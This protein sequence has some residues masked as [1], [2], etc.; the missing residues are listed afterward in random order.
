MS[1]P[2]LSRQRPSTRQPRSAAPP[3]PPHRLGDPPGTSGRLAGRYRY[4]RRTI[5]W[6]SQAAMGIAAVTLAIANVG[7]WL[8]PALI[9]AM[10]FVVGAG[11]A[12]EAPSVQTLLPNIVEPR[13]LPRAVAASSSFGRKALSSSPHFGRAAIRQLSRVYPHG[14]RS[15]DAGGPPI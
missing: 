12:F 8:T 11:R 15:D 2:T 14:R 1:S 3:A 5:S 9:L 4:D 6:L 10:V 13:L 7:A